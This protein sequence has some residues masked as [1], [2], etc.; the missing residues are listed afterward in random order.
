MAVVQQPGSIPSISHP[1][2]IRGPQVSL[3][4]QQPVM[5]V[6]QQPGSI[7]S[8][9]HP[10][11]IRGP[12]V[13]LSIYTATRH[14]CRTAARVNSVHVTSRCHQGASGIWYKNL[15]A[16]AERVAVARYQMICL[17][18][19]LV[20]LDLIRFSLV[21]YFCDCC[22]PL[23]VRTCLIAMRI[24]RG[25]WYGIENIAH[26]LTISKI[27]MIFDKG[28][29]LMIIHHWNIF[30]SVKVRKSVVCW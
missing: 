22:Q 14:G 6:V 8:M 30:R 15:F 28:A 19:T 24:C 21:N 5:A 3:S 12:Q 17:V 1:A 2:A 16:V 25:S 23:V 20:K 4:I 9:S 7:P 29:S 13:S 27:F 10:A 18:L 11:A 26:V